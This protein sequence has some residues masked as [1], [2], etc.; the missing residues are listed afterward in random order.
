[1]GNS[2]KHKQQNDDMGGTK[3]V[4]L[5]PIT[6]MTTPKGMKL[7]DANGLSCH[8]NYIAWMLLFLWLDRS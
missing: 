7:K 2:E 8:L 4:A 5:L 1:M 6:T 3:I